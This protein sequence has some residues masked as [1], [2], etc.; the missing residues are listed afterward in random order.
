MGSTTAVTNSTGTLLT[1]D[2]APVVT[3]VSVPANRTYAAA[4]NLDF[5]VNLSENVTVNTTGGTPR[6]TLTVGSSTRFANYI[7]GS[8]SS[9]LVFRYTVPSGDEDT[10]GIA[11]SAAIDPNSGTLQDTGGNDIN[12]TLN[13]IGSLTSVLVDAL[14]PSS[15]RSYTCYNTGE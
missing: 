8:G 11:L 4:S 13:S 10:D 5:T 7:S 15:C 9:A 2:I 1:D 6:L 3:S 14:R 12:T